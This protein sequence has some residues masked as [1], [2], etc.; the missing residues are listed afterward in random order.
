MACKPH[1]NTDFHQINVHTPL[2]WGRRGLW[3]KKTYF[4]CDY[5]TLFLCIKS[6]IQTLLFF[7]KSCFLSTLFITGCFSSTVEVG[8]GANPRY[9]FY[10]S[11]SLSL[12][13]AS[14][15]FGSGSVLIYW[16]Y[17]CE[18]PGFPLLRR[19]VQWPLCTVSKPFVDTLLHLPTLSITLLM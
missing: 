2:P 16:F 4:Q 14:S 12:T 18:I 9:Q 13:P 10:A 5:E 8:F 19:H 7:S 1:L 3:I 17:L 15:C 11:H 6:D